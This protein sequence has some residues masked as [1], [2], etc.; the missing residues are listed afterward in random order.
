MLHEKEIK[1]EFT[2]SEFCF[3][4]FVIE[5]TDFGQK[6]QLLKLFTQMTFSYD[7]CLAHDP[8]IFGLTQSPTLPQFESV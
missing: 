5:N 7:L 1:A 8:D 4:T 6:G 2:S 3:D